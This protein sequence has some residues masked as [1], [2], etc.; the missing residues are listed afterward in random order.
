MNADKEA[1]VDPNELFWMDTKSIWA[2][3]VDAWDSTLV[4]FQCRTC[5]KLF[6]AKGF[7]AR[8]RAFDKGKMRCIKAR[9][10]SKVCAWH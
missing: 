5:G 3:S 6:L 1:P 4:H 2:L 8:R 10:P 7:V 9:C